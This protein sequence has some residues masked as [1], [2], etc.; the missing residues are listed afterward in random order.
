MYI[1]TITTQPSY[2]DIVPPF[3]NEIMVQGGGGIESTDVDVAI[4]D[5][6]GNYISIPFR[7]RFK[8]MGA[9]LG[10]HM[11]GDDDDDGIVD[12]LSQNGISTVSVISGN[13]PGAVQLRVELFP[14]N[15]GIIDDSQE[16]IAVAEG[17]PVTI[18][19]GPPAQGVI[20]YSYVDITTIG[21]GLYQIP[22]SV[23]IWDIHSNP[24]ADSTNV[25]FSVRGYAPA[26]NA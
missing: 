19:T 20:N 17:T 8:L 11:D 22:V 23:D 26:Y 4:K 25:Y 21:G 12:V 7:V 24:V 9:P 3:P 13:R 10:C 18:A 6:T 15:D 1:N 2:I 5:G 14:D 16:P